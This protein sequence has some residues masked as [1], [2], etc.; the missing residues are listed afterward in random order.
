MNRRHWLIGG[1][2]GLIIGGLII[3][4]MYTFG[5]NPG[6]P[7]SG[8]GN[9]CEGPIETTV[10]VIE[11]VF[12]LPIMIL[13]SSIQ[14]IDSNLVLSLITFFIYSFLIGAFI[15][16]IYEKIKRKLKGGSN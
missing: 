11:L 10:A 14:I 1:I 6:V 15:G 8:G 12:M 3:L 2:I 7:G 13:Q 9:Y 16:Y 5:C 4:H